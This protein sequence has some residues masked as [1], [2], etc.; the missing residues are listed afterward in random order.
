[1]AGPNAVPSSSM[2]NKPGVVTE[3]ERDA[4]KLGYDTAKSRF[5]DGEAALRQAKSNLR[6]I[7]ATEKEIEDVQRAYVYHNSKPTE[8]YVM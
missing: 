7:E 5:D 4:I 8:V 1:M 2:G 3:K 6:K